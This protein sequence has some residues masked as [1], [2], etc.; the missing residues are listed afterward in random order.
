M[1]RELIERTAYQMA[2]EMVRTIKDV[3]RPE[4]RRDAFECFLET[5]LGQLEAYE[6]QAGRMQ[7][8]KPSN[9]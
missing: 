5:C 8:P 2:V 4:E 3:L 6:A 7:V 9:N 1:Q